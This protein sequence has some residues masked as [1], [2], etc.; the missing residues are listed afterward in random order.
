MLLAVEFVMIRNKAIVEMIQPRVAYGTKKTAL[1]KNMVF[2]SHT[3]QNINSFAALW[4]V[5][6]ARGAH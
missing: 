4:L 1:V 3:F 2:Y 5:T 6:T